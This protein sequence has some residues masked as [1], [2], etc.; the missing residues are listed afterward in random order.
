VSSYVQAYSLLYNV[1]FTLFACTLLCV[2]LQVRLTDFAFASALGSPDEDT[3][4]RAAKAIG[5]VSRHPPSPVFISSLLIKED[6]QVRAPPTTKN[7]S[8]IDENN[9]VVRSLIVRYKHNIVRT[10]KHAYSDE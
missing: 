10:C 4:R 6:L 1:H 3:I 5:S 7:S 2:S 9:A 8:W